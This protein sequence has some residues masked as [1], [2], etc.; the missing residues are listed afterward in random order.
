MDKRYGLVIDLE[1]CIGCQTCTI[2]CKLE[3]DFEKG[4]GIQVETVG[5]P[6]QDTPSGK[7]PNLSM[8]YIPRMCMHCEK[9]PCA[10]VCPEDAISKGTNG[11]V[12]L[13]EGLCTGCQA[14]LP[15]CP[16]NALIFDDEKNIARKCNLCNHR[17]DKGLEPFCVMCCETE[18]I[19]FGDLNDSGSTVS[20]LISK[21]KAGLLDSEKGTGPGVYYCPTKQGRIT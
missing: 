10:D 2:A 5:G 6:H 18:A 4:S 9:P 11:M 17:L 8:H 12:L 20:Q 15:E 14:C 16:Y 13:D 19:F 3:N 7:Y 21:R 1:R